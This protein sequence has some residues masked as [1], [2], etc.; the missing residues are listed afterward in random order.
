MHIGLAPSKQQPYL[1]PNDITFGGTTFL[2]DLQ[3]EVRKVS[4][5]LTRRRRLVIG[6][7]I[8]LH[9]NWSGVELESP[10]FRLAL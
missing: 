8:I 2:P 6:S 3:L 7:L 10:L 9:P 1:P 5:S 4:D